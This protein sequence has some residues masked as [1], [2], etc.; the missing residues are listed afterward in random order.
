MPHHLVLIHVRDVL[1]ISSTDL[2]GVHILMLTTHMA[3][4]LQWSR[5]LEFVVRAVICP[6]WRHYPCTKHTEINNFSVQELSSTCNVQ[7]KQNI[8]AF[9]DEMQRIAFA[10]CY[11]H[12]C[13]SVC[14][15]VC[16]CV[17]AAFVDLRKTVWDR[18]R[19]SFKML[20]MTP[21]VTCKSFTQIGLQIPR[22][23][24][25]SDNKF[26]DCR[27]LLMQRLHFFAESCVMTA[28]ISCRSLTQIRLQIPRW[29]TKWRLCKAR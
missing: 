11:R 24:H 27:H 1:E 19:F 5:E 2:T 6:H 12:V 4:H 10:L 22:C 18:R 17:S 21:D 14:V 23:W 8:Y 29:R 15:C 26:K 3:A 16:V 9:L 25:K 7:I 20:G 13:V 28:H